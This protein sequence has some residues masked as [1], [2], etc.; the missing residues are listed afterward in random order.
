MIIQTADPANPILRQ[1]LKND[2]R[3]MSASQLEERYLFGYPPFARII[4]IAIK[5]RDQQELNISAARLAENLRRHLGSIVLGP[6]FPQVM[7]VQ[8]WYIKNIMI[9]IGAG[10]S[11]SKVKEIIRRETE[12]ELKVPRRGLLRIQADVDPQ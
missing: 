6:E 10:L 3:S 2:F 5:H 12:N 11:Q 7:Q 1:V 9:K 4:R 8:K